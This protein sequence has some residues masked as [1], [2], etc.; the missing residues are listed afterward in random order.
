[1]KFLLDM[2]LPRRLVND[3]S[4]N[5]WDTVHIAEIAAPTTPD[6]EIVKLAARE[7]R[8]IITSDNDFAQIIALKGWTLPSIINIREQNLKRPKVFSLLK[9]VIPQISLELEKGCI[10]SVTITEARVRKLPIER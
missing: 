1:M 10:V 4:E 3:L 7:G 2:A 6:L 5:H 8:I 9:E